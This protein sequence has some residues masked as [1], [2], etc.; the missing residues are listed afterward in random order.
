MEYKL[1][2]KFGDY[3]EMGGGN[4]YREKWMTIGSVSGLPEP[5]RRA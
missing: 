5:A 4:Q 2:P 1:L 3:G